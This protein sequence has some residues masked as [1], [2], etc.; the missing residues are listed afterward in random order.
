MAK[1]TAKSPAVSKTIKYSGAEKV[2][3]I[4]AD[5][6]VIAHKGTSATLYFFQAQFSRLTGTQ[7]T[8]TAPGYS[9]QVRA[10]DAE[11]QCVSRVAMDSATFD[12]LLRA[13]AKNRGLTLQPEKK[14]EDQS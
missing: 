11:Y 9:Q 3:S 10:S 5:N 13:M 8:G 6:Y 4:F 7:A 14:Q 2:V 1:H 12:G